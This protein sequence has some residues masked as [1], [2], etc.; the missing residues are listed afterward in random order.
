[1]EGWKFL[2]NS[3]EE[4]YND[5]DWCRFHVIA[6]FLDHFLVLNLISNHPGEEVE[7]LLGF[8]NDNQIASP[9]KR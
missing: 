6:E 1:M 4:S 2:G 9:P 7:G 3:S 8:G 5:T